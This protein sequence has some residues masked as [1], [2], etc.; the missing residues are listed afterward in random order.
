MKQ[1]HKMEF[2]KTTINNQDDLQLT[3]YLRDEPEE[4]FPNDKK[5]C[6]V[7]KYQRAS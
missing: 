2:A 7:L 6:Y 3:L 1:F 4:N 5:D